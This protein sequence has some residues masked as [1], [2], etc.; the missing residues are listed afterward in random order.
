MLSTAH[1]T[2]RIIPLQIIYQ[3]DASDSA[4]Q[5]N[6]PLVPRVEAK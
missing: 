3:C 1:F 4:A 6:E 2:V 5:V